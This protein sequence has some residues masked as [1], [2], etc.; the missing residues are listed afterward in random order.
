L[1]IPRRPLSPRGSAGW[2]LAFTIGLCGVA[3]SQV[4]CGADPTEEAG[5]DDDGD[6]DAG[7]NDGVSFTRIYNS[8][9]FQRCAECHAPGAQGRVDGTESTQDWSTRDKAY[10][11]L[12]GVASGMTGNFEGCNGEPLLGSRAETS[13]LVA[14]LDEDVRDGY[15]SAST[16]SCTKDAI[17]DMTLKLGAPLPSALLA[18]LKAW[19]DAGAPNK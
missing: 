19:V 4:G 13:L 17:S 2:S 15:M 1:Y 16:P 9:E 8:P 5:G 14:S 7:S 12:K 11:S 6:S 18:Q 10:A 3:L